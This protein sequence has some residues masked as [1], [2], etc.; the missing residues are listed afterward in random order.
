MSIA[1]LLRNLPGIAMVDVTSGPHDVIAVFEVTDAGVIASE[2]IRKIKT[3]HGVRYV[4]TCFAISPGMNDAE[5]RS[6]EKVDQ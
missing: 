5:G 3:I 2:S 6:V 1:E 4:T